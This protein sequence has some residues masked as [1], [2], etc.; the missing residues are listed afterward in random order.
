MQQGKS[1]ALMLREP[2]SGG[3]FLCEC[4]SCGR[5]ELR[6]PR[7]LVLTPAGA[8]A[9]CRAC[10]SVVVVARTRALEPAG[11]APAEVARAA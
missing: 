2:H 7:S 6:G 9:S 8:T 11:R 3:M 5:R 1:L 4:H 10:G